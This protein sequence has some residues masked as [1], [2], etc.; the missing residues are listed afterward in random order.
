MVQHTDQIEI[1]HS[2]LK[3]SHSNVCLKFSEDT[4]NYV[5][6]LKGQI[7]QK[8]NPN[9]N[10]NIWRRNCDTNLQVAKST[11]A[12]ESLISPSDRNVYY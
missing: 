6:V 1:L 12:R 9:N 10:A 2:L 4:S 5:F 7:K 3:S 11:R 8:K